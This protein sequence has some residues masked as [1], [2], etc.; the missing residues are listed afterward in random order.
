GNARQAIGHEGRSGT[1]RLRT[2]RIGDFR[3]QLQ[4]IDDG[5][6]V[7]EAILARIFDPFFT[8]KP[9]GVGTGLGLSIVLSVVREHGGQVQV[10]NSP[11]GGAIFSV[12]LPAAAENEVESHLPHFSARAKAPALAAALSPKSRA[13]V[14]NVLPARASHRGMRVLVVE[15]EPT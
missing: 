6:G 9:A 5:P 10:S 3:V 12:E 14:A 8:T 2:A 15:D 1:I 11:E 7:P 13:P 4:V